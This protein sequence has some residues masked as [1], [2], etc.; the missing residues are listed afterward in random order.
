MTNLS[1]ENYRLLQELYLMLDD[2]DRR[3]LRQFGLTNRQYHAL[4]HLPPGTN[5][6]L[7]EMS[8]LLFCDKSNIT[9]LVE[10]MVRDGLVTR[11]RSESDRRYLELS[12][13]EQGEMQRQSSRETLETAIQ[14]RFQILNE[15]EEHQLNFLLNKLAGGLRDFLDHYESQLN[16]NGSTS[17]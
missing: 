14:N 15:E 5:R 13:T 17:K 2:S 10:R 1:L 11:D 16:G 7:T 8:E 3:V 12:I 9:G 4:Q 6:H